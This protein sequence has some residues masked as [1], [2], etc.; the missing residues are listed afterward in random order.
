ML[1]L[2]FEL[3][4]MPDIVVVKERDVFAGCDTHA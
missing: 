4:G 3:L 2:P 1:Q